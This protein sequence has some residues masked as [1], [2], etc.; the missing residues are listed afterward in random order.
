MAS[1]LNR[2]TKQ[3]VRS[4]NTPD[5]PTVDWIIDPDMSAV[6]G[7][8]SKYWV[9][10]GDTVSLM[11]QAA[12]D[13]VDAAELSARLDNEAEG[14]ESPQSLQRAFAEVVLDEINMLRQQFNATTAESNQLT[15]TAFA[16]RTLAQVKAALR[17][18]M[19]AH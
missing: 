6:D 8:P 17:N 1:V 12:R 11:D 4:A 3:Y 16:D 7:W 15:N 13:A 5:Y 14:I 19:D 10:T 2:T 18:K 9:I